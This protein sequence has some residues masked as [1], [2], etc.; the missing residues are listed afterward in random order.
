MTTI[1]ARIKHGNAPFLWQNLAPYKNHVFCHW[2]NRNYPFEKKR[3]RV[4]LKNEGR[5][6][7]ERMEV[8]KGNRGLQKKGD[9]A[10]K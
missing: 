4:F 6:L 10:K 5:F 8:P 7:L 9:L 2:L 1:G 3:E